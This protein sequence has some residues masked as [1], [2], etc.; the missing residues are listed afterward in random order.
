MNVTRASRTGK[1]MGPVA[2]LL[3]MG[4]GPMAFVFLALAVFTGGGFFIFA[5]LV[6]LAVTLWAGVTNK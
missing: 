1:P 2:L 3:S 4:A 5:Y 6:Y